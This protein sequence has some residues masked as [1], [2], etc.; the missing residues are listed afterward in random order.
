MGVLR[1]GSLNVNGFRDRVKQ[2]LFAELLSLKQLHVCFLQET[3]STDDMAADYGLWWKGDCFLSHGTNLSL[4]VAVLLA[5]SLKAAILSKSEVVPGRLLVVRASVFEHTFTFINVYAP[6]RG[7][8]RVDFFSKL[9]QILQSVSSGDTVVMGGDWNCTLDF[10]HDRNGEEPHPQSAAALSSIVSGFNL[11]DVWR[12]KHP[13]VKQYTWVKVSEGRVSAARLDRFYVS[14]SVRHRTGQSA[15][16]PTGFSDHHLCTVDFLFVTHARKGCVWYFN[17]KLLQDKA[18][19]ESF[20]VFWHEWVSRK[21]EFETLIQWWEV[22]KSQIRTFCQD[23]TSYST[24]TLRTAIRAL[25]LDIARIYDLLINQSASGLQTDLASKQKELAAIL[26]EKAK[27]AFV[28]SR[29][30]SMNDMDAPTAF[31]FD[32]ERST[33]GHQ[34]LASLRKVDGSVT[35]D[36]VELRRLAVD[37]YSALFA[38]EAL[39]PSCCEALSSGLP[40]LDQGRSQALDAALSFEEV[41]EAVFQLN[42]GRAPGIDG[43]PVDFFKAFWG[44]IGED[45]FSVLQASLHGQILPTSCKRAVLSLLPKKG[46]LCLLKNWRPVSLLCADYKILSRCLANRLKGALDTLIHIDQSYCVPKRSIYDNLFLIRDMMDF[47]GL[48]G[49]EFGLLSLD[50][51][52]AFDRVDHEYLFGT[53]RHLGFGGVFLSWVRLLYTDASCLIKVGGGLSL[54]VPVRRGIRQGCPLSGQLY[55]IAVEP[56]LCLLRTRLV[57]LQFAGSSVRLSAYADDVTVVIRNSED[58]DALKASLS[59]YERA[60]SARL[61]WGKTK[62]VWCGPRAGGR[63]L[64]PLPGAIEWDRKGFKVLG[65]WLGTED[66]KIKNWEGLVE[67]VRARLSRWSWLLPQLSYRGRV[68]IANNLIASA[69]WHKFTVLNPP[70][71][72]IKDIQ[73]A[74]VD[75]FWS[76]QHWLRAAVL[77]LPVQEG[78]QG[79]IDIRSRVAVLR[80]QAAQRFLYHGHHPWIDVACALLRSAGRM[81]LDRHLFYLSLDS[82]DLGGLTPFYSAVLQAWQLLSFSRKE[83]TPAYWVFEE[84]LFFNPVLPTISQVSGT[85]RVSLL[86]A[87]VSKVCHLRRGFDWVTAEQLANLAGLR[88]VRLASQ[89]LDHVRSGLSASALDFLEAT[90]VEDHHSGLAAS[91]ELVVTVERDGWEEGRGKLLSLE[92]PILGSFSGLSKRA[93][94]CVCTKTLNFQALKDLHDTK[95]AE[96]LGSG[97][98]PKGSWRSLYKRPIEKRMGDLQWRLVH[99]ILATN[100]HVARLDPLV[101]EGCPFC[102]VTETVFHL[103]LQCPRLCLLLRAVQNWGIMFLGSFEPSLFIYGP[104]SP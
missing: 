48:S 89:V 20:K 31:F 45:L 101:G 4:G 7:P 58:V 55:A 38:S 62:A 86:E 36:P 2:S 32:L 26:H 21:G 74:L 35:M 97:S 12:E 14:C 63:P 81:G 103:F 44:V 67:K 11:I 90:P 18:F 13:Q 33:A 82:V 19:C 52:K 102:G 24:A 30:L 93:L 15:I 92:I 69:L 72:L 27:G 71:G 91:P 88:S 25:E 29:Y 77:Y 9:D 1:V 5:P 68:L 39:D 42:S 46:D 79:L 84:P 34:A 41:T 70:G 57:G 23:F 54:P 61:N 87:G 76:G 65:V 51:E 28:R 22:G 95:W 85:L 10:V 96:V 75:F 64:P 6:N 60:S 94:Y 83:P 47:A 78:G 98:S 56:L 37:F 66:V 49:T 104:N 53:M 73:K 40:Q 17:R 43:L 3:H 8:D 16:S 59:I 99:G 50:Q 100:R 80:L